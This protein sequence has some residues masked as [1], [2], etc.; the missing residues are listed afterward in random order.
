MTHFFDAAK[1]SGLH[2]K[3]VLDRLRAAV[4]GIDV[5]PVAVHLARSAWALA[6]KPAILAAKESGF[7]A[8]GTV[9]VYLG[10]SLQLRFNPGDMFAAHEVRIAVED[11]Q[12]TELVF[13]AALVEQADNFDALMG[14]ASEYI[15]HGEDPFVALDDHQVNDP[16]ERQT[17]TETLKKLQELHTQGRD[18]IWAYYS[19]N[20]VRPVTLARRKV[21]VIIGNPPWINYNHTAD[22]LRSALETQ[23]KELY[24]IWAGGRYATHQDVAGLFFTRC[25]DLYLKDGGVTG[26]VMP[27][28]A[29]QAGQY[30]KWRSG[31]WQVRRGGSGLTADFSFKTAWDLERLQPNTFFPVPA[32][33]VFARRGGAATPARPLVGTVERWQGVAGADDVRRVGAAITDTGVPGDSPYAGYSRQGAT[34]V[35]RCLFFVHEA[36]NPALVQAGQTVTV[37]PRR[38]GQDKPPWKDLDLTAITG[39]TVESDH[40]FDVHLGE[41]LVPYATLEPLKALLPLRQGESAIPVDTNGVGGVRLGGLDRRMRDRWRTISN[42]WDDNKA[43]ANEL[44]LLG[45]VDYH[46]ELSSQFVWQHCHEERPVRVVYSKSG[47]PTAALLRDDATIVDH[48]L[49]WITCKNDREAYYLLAIIN[50]DALYQRVMP[51]MSK[52]Q[53]GSRDLHKHPLEAAHPRIR[54]LQPVAPG[55]IQGRG[56]GGGRSGKATGAVAAGPPQA[57]GHHRPPGAAQVAAVVNGGQGGGGRRG[58]AA[59]GGVGAY[60]ALLTGEMPEAFYVAP[61]TWLRPAPPSGMRCRR[62][63]WVGR[64]GWGTSG[65]HFRNKRFQTR[66]LK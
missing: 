9:P 33:V 31:R 32:S 15:E 23:S 22:A 66:G 64:L 25:A 21:D 47:E 34:I 50:S 48:L 60:G 28:S 27:H 49:F 12:N 54:G 13:P 5:H 1:Q 7:D 26:M 43:A 11:E 30:S 19:R 29:L 51:L 53:F 61:Q 58:E 3:Q 14:D 17:L 16:Q 4:T 44:N 36:E 52:G 45:R 10:D 59:G 35:P 46:R 24:G 2:P 39:Q 41:T 18:H 56:S 6:A 37:N 38:G 63:W 57:D 20:L 42:F 55:Y 65:D 8:S 62:G 40:L